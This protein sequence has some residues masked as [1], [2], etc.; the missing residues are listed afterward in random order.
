MTETMVPL[1][2]FLGTIGTVLVASVGG[3]W[4]FASIRNRDM[5]KLQEQ[6]ESDLKALYGR[7]DQMADKEDIARLDGSVN[8]LTDSVVQLRG[9]IHETAV[10]LARI[11]PRGEAGG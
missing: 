8:R 7:I 6:R 1:S 10:E 11:R 2:W 9:E 3:T 4:T 5:G